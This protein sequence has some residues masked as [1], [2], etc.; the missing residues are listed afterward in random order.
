[1]VADANRMIICWCMGL[2]QH[3]NAVEGI[4][5][6]INLLLLGGHIGKPGAGAC[7]VRG[8]SNVQG[9]R[10][11]G[12]WERPPAAFLD[13]LE[14]EFHFSAPRKHGHD[15]VDT[16]KAMQN[17]A[18]KVFVGLGGNFLS[19]A[20]DTAYTATAMSRCDLTVYVST[21]LNRGHLIPGKQAL[22]LPTLG[23]SE[24]D[25]G[26]LGERFVTVE[27][28]M[29][30]VSSS[31]G[32]LD[33]ASPDLLSE[34]AIVARLAKAILG[35]K[36]T[37]NWDALEADYDRIRDHIAHIV[38]GFENFNDR[39]RKDIFYLPNAARD[40]REFLTTTGKANFT[41]HDIPRRNLGRG[42]FLMTTIR[43]HDQFNTTI[44]GLDDRYRGIY[45]GRRV[46]FLN[47]ED[48]VAQGLKAG[49]FVDITSHFEGE[50]RVAPRFKVVPYQIPRQCA[51]TYYPEANVLVSVR[52]VDA[53]SNEPASKSVRITLAPSC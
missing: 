35:R 7:C 13:A 41:V 40:R 33:S 6:L 17:G 49:D 34:P 30:V 27:D 2:T 39:I 16:I 52:S 21:K 28:S 1:M 44:Y 15:V 3:H 9:D 48:L 8:H 19:A 42:E 43:S 10:T 4:Q 20:P 25:V 23:R 38:S 26:P 12:I 24:K 36:S 31:R 5:E 32:M 45:G 29:G 50:K 46:I 53:K 14:R 18:I 37:V 11:M 22:I 47:A 51:A